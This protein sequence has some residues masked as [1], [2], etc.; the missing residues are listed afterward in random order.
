M[1]DGRPGRQFEPRARAAIYTSRVAATISGRDTTIRM[2]ILLLHHEDSPL[3][4]PWVGQGW[5]DVYDVARSGWD[6]YD[7][8]FF[9]DRA[10]TEIYT[11]SLH[12]AL[13]VLPVPC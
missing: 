2:R 8:F 3:A 11:L 5:S 12:D 7:L 10:T 1:E 4:G 9:T 13:H 6:S